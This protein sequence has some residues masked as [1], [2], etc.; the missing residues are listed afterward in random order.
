MA[1]GGWRNPVALQKAYQQAD[2]ATVRAVMDV[3]A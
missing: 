1:A 2:P 3:G